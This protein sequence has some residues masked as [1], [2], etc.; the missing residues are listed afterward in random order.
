MLLEK[1]TEGKK[2]VHCAFVDLEKAYDR[3]P[4]EELWECLRLAET[5]ECYMR[6]I[7]DMHDGATTTVRCATGLS[8]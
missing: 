1:W 2:A 8:D 5:S 6:S 4:R 7:K 3:V